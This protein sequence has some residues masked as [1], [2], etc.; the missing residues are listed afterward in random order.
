MSNPI[1]SLEFERLTEVQT[2]V[3]KSGKHWI[4]NF[5][6]NLRDAGIRWSEDDA[7]SLAASVAYYLALS[8]FPMMLVLTSGF[9]I[10]L[11]FSKTGKKAEEQILNMVETHA[12]PIIKKQIEQVLTSL[13][14]HSIVSGPFGFLAATLAAIGIFAQ[15][16]RGFELCAQPS[17]ERPADLRNRDADDW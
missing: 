1:K 7:S 11:Q 15:I 3:V 10:F 4:R 14:N 17:P 6:P 13:Q 8:L 16:D 9:G 12:S 5:F 2:A